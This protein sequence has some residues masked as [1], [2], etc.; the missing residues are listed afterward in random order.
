MLGLANLQSD[1]TS[2]KHGLSVKTI[3]ELIFYIGPSMAFVDSTVLCSSV[4]WQDEKEILKVTVLL[5]NIAMMSE[6]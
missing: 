5:G 2:G 6:S 3:T 4:I 1:N